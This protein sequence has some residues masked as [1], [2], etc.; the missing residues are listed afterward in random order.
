MTNA[1]QH[2]MYRSYAATLADMVDGNA[3]IRDVERA[4]TRRRHGA[5]V[6]LTPTTAPLPVGERPELRASPARRQATVPDGTDRRCALCG[7]T[8][9]AAQGLHHLRGTAVHAH[10][11]RACAEVQ[12]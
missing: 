6:P 2:A 12:R 3:R 10:C 11:D 5:G 8:I 4:M 7:R 9:R 1:D